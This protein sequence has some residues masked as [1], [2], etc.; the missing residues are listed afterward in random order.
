MMET[1]VP[2]V[3]APGELLREELDA[4]GW[5]QADL[6][7][8]LGRPVRLVHE[9]L[10]AK[11]A[12]TP[13]TAQGLADA[14]GTSAEFWMNLE[15]Q[16]QLARARATNVDVARRARVFSLAPVKEMQRRGWIA[17]ARAV[18]DLEREVCRFFGHATLDDLE[19]PADLPHAAKKSTAYSLP[20]SAAQRAWVTRV[21]QLGASLD[22]APYTL[23]SVSTAL[24]LLAPL[25]GALEETR[26]IPRLLADLGIRL[27]VVEPL[28]GTRIDGVCTWLDPAC[29][30]IGLSLRFDRV[31]SFWFAL[32]H[33]LDHVQQ[34]E[35]MDVAVVDVDLV[36]D[37]VPPAAERPAGE[38]RADRFAAQ[39]LIPD[40]E[41]AGFIAR[42]RPLYSRAQIVGFAA[43]IGVHPGLVVGQL[44]HRQEILYSHSRDLL[45]KV[46]DVVTATA[47]T[48]GWGH[49]PGTMHEE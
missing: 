21:R 4:R 10:A 7:E 37:R 2:T 11:R 40:R 38:Q 33:E 41:L 20:L 35:G 19:R 12:I 26:R 42:V 36:G 1:R 31:D 44:Q 29:P 24:N 30:V 17:P 25:R 27:V 5:T 18:D 8:V 16:Y 32:L 48:D 15:S 45:A 43:R 22:A 13:E 9:L 23:S 49:H 14:L 28:A 39:A 6:A 47:M 3:C 46:R 34:R